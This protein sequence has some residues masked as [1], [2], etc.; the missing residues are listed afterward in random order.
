M[1]RRYS[2][3]QSE[4]IPDTDSEKLNVEKHRCIYLCKFIPTWTC[5]SWLAPPSSGTTIVAHLLADHLDCVAQ[6]VLIQIEYHTTNL[7][8]LADHLDCSNDR[9]YHHRRVLS[10]IDTDR[11]LHDRILGSVSLFLRHTFSP[12]FLYKYF[13]LLLTHHRYLSL[14]PTRR[15]GLFCINTPR[16]ACDYCDSLGPFL[17][18]LL[19]VFFL[20]IGITFSFSC[21]LYCSQPPS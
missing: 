11:I 16:T 9:L 4:W 20:F 19:T 2:L 12:Y 17:V 1:I 21:H 14:P 7:N 8:S 10:C 18:S 6:P 13:S 5:D 15:P 3:E